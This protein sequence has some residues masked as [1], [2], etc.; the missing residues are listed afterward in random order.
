MLLDQVL[1]GNRLNEYGAHLSQTDRDQARGLMVN[2]RDQ[3][4]TR[5]RNCLL[6]AYGISK[7]RRTDAVDDRSRSGRALQSP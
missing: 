5:I 2:Q 4:R 6:A 1:T 3:M 7:D